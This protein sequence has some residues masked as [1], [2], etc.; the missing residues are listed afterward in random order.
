[1]KL[2]F[3]VGGAECVFEDLRNALAQFTPD[4]Y[5]ATNAI[6]ANIE[7]LNVWCT[8]HPEFMEKWEKQRLERGL[9]KNYE[10]VAPLKSEVGMHGE[11]GGIDRRVTYRF[12]G[13]GSSASS[14]IYAAK[15]AIEDGYKAILIG[16]PLDESEHFER[17][18][19]WTDSNQFQKGFSKALPY[20]K[21]H[22]RSMSGRTMEA[23]G[24]PTADWILGEKAKE[25]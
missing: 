9:S 7:K 25:S 20:I 24:L 1:M 3:I 12:P 13:M 19:A 10:K 15:V 4:A 14:G 8:L 11:K 17:K 18:K 23:L 22:A 16:V 5:Y 2:A 21:E 6:G